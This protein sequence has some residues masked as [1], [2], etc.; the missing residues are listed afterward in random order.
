MGWQYAPYP[1]MHIS[2]KD[3]TGCIK[4]LQLK[5]CE[6]G[7]SKGKTERLPFT[8]YLTLFL[9]WAIWLK[10]LPETNANVAITGEGGGKETGQRKCK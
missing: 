7:M 10:K 9:T 6:H 4:Q 5:F 3:Q 1:H 2:V 8:M